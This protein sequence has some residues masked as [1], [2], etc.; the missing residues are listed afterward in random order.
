[1]LV[2]DRMIKPVLTITPEIPIHEALNIL[3][4]QEIRHIPVL[5]GGKLVGLVTNEDLFYASPSPATSLSIWDMNYLISKVTVKDVMTENVITVTEETPIEEAALI[6]AKHKIGCLPVMRNDDLVGIIT[7]TDMLK[8]LP[9]LLALHQS[10]IRATFLV[11]EEPGQLAKVTRVIADRGG[12]FIS[13]VQFAANNPDYR[14]VTIKVDGL[15]SEAV[16]EC[17]DPIVVK[18]VDLRKN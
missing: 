7:E 1:M 3:K 9:E 16:R 5:Q 17:L 11:K 14:L 6:M 4:N 10:G 2:C 12:N 18:V 13:L 15:S 8:I